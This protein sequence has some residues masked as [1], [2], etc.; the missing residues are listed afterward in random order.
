MTLAAAAA[1][2][3]LLALNWPNGAEQ[4]V[5]AGFAFA[6]CTAVRLPDRPVAR[7]MTDLSLTLYLAHSLVI[8]ILMRTTSI[9]IKSQIMTA[10]AVAGT[11]LLA[12]SLQKIQRNGTSG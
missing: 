8:S 9:P 7:R 12:L 4:L 5:I 1:A 3:P 11:I 2:G 10:C 6:L